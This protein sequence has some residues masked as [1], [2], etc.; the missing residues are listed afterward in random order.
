MTNRKGKSYDE[1][2]ELKFEGEYLYNELLKGKE[3]L[4]WKI[5]I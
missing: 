3:Y 1:S 2:G 4:K 5:G